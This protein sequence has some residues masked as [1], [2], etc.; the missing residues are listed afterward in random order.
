MNARVCVHVCRSS[1]H[2]DAQRMI[3]CVI[4]NVFGQK[5]KIHVFITRTAFSLF[6]EDLLTQHCPL[7][8][9]TM[10]SVSVGVGERARSVAGAH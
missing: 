9:N 6:F 3:L 4:Y 5:N 10:P 7:L 1:L 8:T 2:L